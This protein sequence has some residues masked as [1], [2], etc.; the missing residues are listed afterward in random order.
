MFLATAHSVYLLHST[1]ELAA[2]GAYKIVLLLYHVTVL[3]FY[4]DIM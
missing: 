3:T 4:E 1:T 2:S